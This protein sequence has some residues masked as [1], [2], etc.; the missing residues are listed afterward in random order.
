MPIH[1]RDTGSVLTLSQ[2]DHPA[3]ASTLERELIKARDSEIQ[4]M[5]SSKDWPD[6]TQRRGMVNG[7]NAAI[8]ICEQVRQKLGA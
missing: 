5:V 4:G 3:L 6:F 8:S 1:H 2:D 7:L